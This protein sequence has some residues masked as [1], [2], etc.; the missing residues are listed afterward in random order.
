MCFLDFA[1]VQKSINCSIPSQLK[2]CMVVSGV[3][4]NRISLIRGTT[5]M[6][7]SHMNTVP[8]WSWAL[9]SALTCERYQERVAPPTPWWRS[10]LCTSWNELATACLNIWSISHLDIYYSTIAL[11]TLRVTPRSGNSTPSLVP[12]RDLSGQPHTTQRLYEDQGHAIGFSPI[13]PKEKRESCFPSLSIL[14][15]KGVFGVWNRRD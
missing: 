4:R 8:T 9:M 15:C 13:I 10:I 11:Q 5:I 14:F 3:W 12:P 6:F 1:K 7:D 2:E